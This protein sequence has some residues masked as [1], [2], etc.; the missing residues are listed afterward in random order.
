MGLFSNYDIEDVIAEGDSATVYKCAHSTHKRTVAVKVLSQQLMNRHPEVTANFKRTFHIA[1]KLNHPNIVQVIER[2]IVGE[3]P[4][5][6]MQYVDGMP[7][8]DA[9]KRQTLDFNQKLDVA[10]QISKALAYAHKNGV[11]HR[12]L[13]PSNILISSKG[14]ILIADFGIAQLVDVSPGEPPPAADLPEYISPEQK[15]G[16]SALTA[17]TDVY[18][19]GVLLY[20]MFTGQYPGNP[21]SLPSSHDS[22]IPAYLDE[23]ITTCLNPD[24][25]KRYASA[26]GVKNKLLESMWGAH[27][28][29]A[30]KERALHDMGDINTRL[31]LLDVV[32]ENRFGG[33]YLC[34]NSVNHNSLI[35]KKVVGTRDGYKEC[36]ILSNLQHPNVVNIY[37]TS[38]D[39]GV[40]IILMEYLAGGSLNDR[41]VNPWEWRKAVKAVKD[42]CQGMVFIHD[43]KLVHG[44]LRPS[45]ILFT[46]QGTAKVADCALNAHYLEE[47]A[48]A[49]W[50]TYPGEP[51]NILADVYSVGAILFEMVTGIVPVRK[52]NELVVND[53]FYSLPP[54][55]QALLKR[56]LAVVPK[57]R[58]RDFRETIRELDGLG[59]PERAKKQKEKK[60]SSG[61]PKSLLFILM[62]TVLLALAFTYSDT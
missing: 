41:L 37:G 30:A 47:P 28:E 27:I 4:Y 50:Y 55:L 22:A 16:R 21:L 12:N 9:L 48:K 32:Q 33:I 31:A 43:N 1:A 13:K 14:K 40:F 2:G 10:L 8:S 26:E 29:Q 11:I 46:R 60:K 53:R 5:L 34:E 20:E 3:L 24:P 61:A 39:E 49:N 25:K 58:Y 62:V 44:N 36:T 7:L 17:A 35:V 23:V 15:S 51:K 19:L 18:A 45:T 59:K 52:H 54:D 57:D 38:T 42:I 6:V 56:L